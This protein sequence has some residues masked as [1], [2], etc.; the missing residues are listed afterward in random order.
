MKIVL[1]VKNFGKISQAS[2]DISRFTIFVGNNNS[3][4]TYLMQL[5]YGLLQQIR[6]LKSNTIRMDFIN[7]EHD[8][9]LDSEMYDQINNS[10]NVYFQEKKEEVVKQI[11]HENIPIEQ[12]HVKLIPEENDHIEVKYR[13]QEDH[14]I[15]LEDMKISKTPIVWT[16]VLYKQNDQTKF[17]EEF[18]MLQNKDPKNDM[19]RRA[20][21]YRE[22]LCSIFLTGTMKSADRILYLPASRPG[23]LLLYKYFFSERDQEKGAYMIEAAD[24]ITKVPVELYLSGDEDNINDMGLTAPVYDFLQ[25]LL[26]YS[27]GEGT[28]F[29]KDLLSFIQNHLLD[30]SIESTMG[31]FVYKQ[32]NSD[33][34]VPLYLASS[35][36]NELTPIVMALS[37][38][39]RYRYILYD[40]IETCLH[41]MKQKEMARLLNR[42]SNQGYRLIVSTHSDTMAAK[43]NNLF[44]LSFMEDKEKQKEKMQRLGLEEADLLQN[45]KVNVYQFT[46]Q[47]NGTSVVE[48]M[49]FQTT[50]Y[51]GYDF[52]MFAESSEELYKESE[53]ILEDE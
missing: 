41:P 43:L 38:R 28:D 12:L 15:R 24:K 51:M 37:N 6:E 13:L 21:I 32:N 33:T 36:V 17:H 42:M 45:E 31:G 50:P 46:N 14:K 53:I 27:Q 10:L 18:G 3:G 23:I 8:F 47:P 52:S 9:M 25:F 16:T 30:G 34:V 26:R 20:Q 35:M 39:V 49:N 19:I 44:L 7:L 29:D 40:E 4:K 2:V 22:L 5:I 48:E 1:S 11:F